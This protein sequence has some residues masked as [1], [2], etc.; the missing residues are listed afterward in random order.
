MRTIYHLVLRRFWEENAD[1]PYRPDS[2]AG[3]GFIHC[4]FAEQAA[5][6]ANRFYAEA[7]D[8]LLLHIDPERLTSPLREEASDT[9]ESFPHI[10]GPLNRDAVVAVEAL[11]RGSDGL[12]QF[13]GS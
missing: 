7:A 8:L 2:L 1:Q 4:S 5:R 10:Y 12:W 3:E 13:S 6:S 11:S 9:G